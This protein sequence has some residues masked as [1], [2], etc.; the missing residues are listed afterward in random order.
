MKPTLIFDL[1]DVLVAGLNGSEGPLAS[2]LGVPAD[3]VL[4]AFRGF[5][6]ETWC[7]GLISED[8]YLR[9][10]CE[11]KGWDIELDELKAGLRQ[12]FQRR[13]PGMEAL[14]AHLVDRYNLMLLADVGAEWVTDIQ[15]YHPW[16]AMF[17]PQFFS[18][19]LRLTKRDP[20]IFRQ[21]VRKAHQD[22][23]NCLVVESSEA[24]LR[25]AAAAGLR[26]LLF[27]GAEQLAQDL[28]LL[29]V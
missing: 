28:A 19:E 6:L 22:A 16:L 11:R 27:T 24:N 2:R 25:T 29:G 14:L 21:V 5:L 12:N 13:V 10:V 17:D 3:T 23:G 20:L 7:C 18:Y 1:P 8:T 15:A 9:L 26:G 4:P